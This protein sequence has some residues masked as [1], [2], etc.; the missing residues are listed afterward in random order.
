MNAHVSTWPTAVFKAPLLRG[1]D[2]RGRREL[3]SCGELR[4]LATDEVVYERGDKSDYV[5]VVADGE[6]ALDGVRRGDDASVELRRVVASES[7]GEEASV[8]AAFR[9]TARAVAASTVAAIP[10]PMF[11]R[12]L[13]RAE[14]ARVI[15]EAADPLT[16]ERYRDYQARGIFAEGLP[17]E[18]AAEWSQCANINELAALSPLLES[19][20]K[21]C[22]LE[23]DL[24]APSSQPLRQDVVSV[25]AEACRTNARR[26]CAT[27]AFRFAL[28]AD[29]EL[30]VAL[31][32]L[33]ARSGHCAR[34]GH[35]I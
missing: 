34:R 19:A 13:A 5:F 18:L 33:R 1:L 32:R 7:F 15:D 20:L 25:V 23:V 8:G 31:L 17:E 4:E 12:A 11:Q 24:A 27:S 16:M 35:S 22:D 29:L 10:V 3:A 6:I 9:A 2:D 21:A 26:T 30:G 14:A 28:G